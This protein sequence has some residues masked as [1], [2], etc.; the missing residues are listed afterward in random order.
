MSFWNRFR[1]TVRA[2]AHGVIDALEDRALVLKQHLREAELELQRKRT[3]LDALERERTR[4][5]KDRVR[6]QAERL[7]LDRDVELA[8]AEDK[9]E[10]ARHT[11]KRLLPLEQLALRIDDRLESIA[12]E[13]RAL[14]NLLAQQEAAL[15]ELQVR[16]GA[17]LS[18]Q[19]AVAGEGA[20]FGPRPV[21]PE[22]IELELLRRKRAQRQQGHGAAQ[23][24][25]A[26]PSDVER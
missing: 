21:E 7:R 11:L 19:S 26:E 23:Q 15:S 16:V 5:L 18:E 2:D 13:Q 10:L 25:T 14:G 3:A 22:T 12:H 6:A 4:L 9:D 24:P 8:L 1:T 20:A 17:F